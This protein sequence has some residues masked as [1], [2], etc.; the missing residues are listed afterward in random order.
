MNA[1]SNEEHLLCLI[2]V[3]IKPLRD[4]ISHV[5][6]NVSHLSKCVE[7]IET[8]DD[9]I[10][11][12]NYPP[13]A[14]RDFSINISF[15]YNAGFAL[16]PNNVDHADENAH[17][18]WENTSD[19][20]AKMQCLEED[21][22][23]DQT[24]EPNPY[25]YHL[26]TLENN[27]TSRASLSPVQDS[28][29]TILQDLWF[30][31]CDTSHSPSKVP[32]PSHLHKPFWDY[33]Q[34][35]IAACCIIVDMAAKNLIHG[36]KHPLPPTLANAWGHPPI[37]TLG[38][39]VNEP[40]ILSLSDD[41]TPPPPPSTSPWNIVGGKNGQ[42]FAKVAA[43]STPT[44]PTP[45][46]PLICQAQT[47]TITL[48]QLTVMSKAQVV[49]A[50]NLRFSP[51]ILP[52]CHSKE[53]VIA[54]YFDWASRPISKAKA[55]TPSK[56]ICKTEYTLIRDPC[57]GSI[58]GLSGCCGDTADLVRMIQYH[59]AQSGV[60]SPAQVIGG[61]WSNQTSYNFVLMFN[62]N[63]SHDKVLCLQNIFAKVFRPHH[64]LAP[65]RGYMRV[66]MGFIPTMR[67]DPSDP[68]PS[69]QSLHMEFS[70]NE[71]MKDLITFGDPYWLMARNP[72]S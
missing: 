6:G 37:T 51:R 72:E 44:C 50:F 52:N 7:F 46:P 41:T 14:G 20:N 17:L 16:D 18:K 59:V 67:E 10:N 13:D 30:E 54:A 61:R 43:A 4:D 45:T 62:G 25:F 55:P 33:H 15:D 57:A 28:A 49:N 8:A 35:L 34:Q 19:I 53:G 23:G 70:C 38:G 42:T 40:I 68:L 71:V 11:L 47:G 31:F 5:A 21:T 36:A 48:E 69:P 56:P 27:L 29:I 1:E 12:H 24:N 65:S 66:T 2:G 60:P 39:S 63:P 22:G 64:M 9:G 26:Y 58:A 3:A 32:I